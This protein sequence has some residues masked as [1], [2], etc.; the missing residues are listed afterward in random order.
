MTAVWEDRTR[1][2]GQ[3]RFQNVDMKELLRQTIG[4]S[5]LGG[6]KLTGRFDFSGQDVDALND[7]R[8]HLVASF[9]QA[10]ALQVPVL[11][12]RA[13]FLGIGPTT[14]FQK[15]DL[16]AAPRPRSWRIQQLALQGTALQVHVDGTVTTEGRLNL[17]V[18][19][20]TGNLGL[21]LDKL[22]ILSAPRRRQGLFPWASFRKRPTSW[23]AASSTSR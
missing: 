17:E 6:G 20:K 15:G 3:L 10:Q 2:E 22:G 16:D 14:T 13:P 7:L 9:D 11:Q 12:Q 18:A 23:P 19:A 1:L 21:P 4:P 5:Q 8:G